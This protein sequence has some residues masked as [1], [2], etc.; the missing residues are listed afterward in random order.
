M[1]WIE[2]LLRFLWDFII[3]D[4]WRIAVGVV[5][6]LGVTALG[7]GSG[8]GATSTGTTLGRANND[9]RG[10][11]TT[12]VKKASAPNGIARHGRYIY[13]AN[14]NTQSIG[15]AAISGAGASPKFI[16]PNDNVTSVAVG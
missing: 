5:L 8:P 3:G 13:W 2:S 6:A 10:L 14:A 1:R 7:T 12:L 15:R 16:S 4:D 9:G 11:K